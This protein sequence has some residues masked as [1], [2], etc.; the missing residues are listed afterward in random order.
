M[1]IVCWKCDSGCTHYKG[2]WIVD[3]FWFL[4]KQTYWFKVSRARF[5]H[6]ALHPESEKKFQLFSFMYVYYLRL[7]TKRSLFFFQSTPDGDLWQPGLFWVSEWQLSAYKYQSPSM[8]AICTP[9][10]PDDDAVYAQAV[11]LPQPSLIAGIYW[12]GLF[13]RR[14]G[15]Y[16]FSRLSKVLKK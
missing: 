12:N 10:Y 4:K 1:C 11:V 7:D 14:E 13:L 6:T 5:F 8:R 15:A 2:F 16:E 9:P 3:F